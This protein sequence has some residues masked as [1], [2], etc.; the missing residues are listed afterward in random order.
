LSGAGRRAQYI[1]RC[2]RRTVG[3]LVARRSILAR[4]LALT[5]KVLAERGYGL[6]SSTGRECLRIIGGDDCDLSSYS[7]DSESASWFLRRPLI[8][9]AS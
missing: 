4:Q 1:Y 3:A 8:P 2:R 6:L 9:P 5:E 7:S